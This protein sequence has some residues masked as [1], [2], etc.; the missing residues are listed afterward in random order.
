VKA[1]AGAI[2]NVN[3]IAPVRAANEQFTSLRDSTIISFVIPN[4]GR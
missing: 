4:E 1:E 3:I 2:E